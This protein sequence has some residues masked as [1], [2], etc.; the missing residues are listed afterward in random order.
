[1]K[2]N[3]K[4]RKFFE[5]DPSFGL[6]ATNYLKNGQNGENGDA[7]KFTF[8]PA[9]TPAI[10]GPAARMNRGAMGEKGKKR[11]KRPK[12]SAGF[13]HLAVEQVLERNFRFGCELHGVAV[14]GERERGHDVVAVVP[15]HAK[16]R[17]FSAQAQA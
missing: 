14:E 13:F 5:A 12:R 10:S 9:S 6:E 8:S 11:Q 17:G 2:K 16:R 1:M 3:E 7:L 15:F 4:K